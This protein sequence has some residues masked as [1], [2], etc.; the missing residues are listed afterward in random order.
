MLSKLRSMGGSLQALIADLYRSIKGRTDVATHPVTPDIPPQTVGE[1]EGGIKK[2]ETSPVKNRRPRVEQAILR[3][4]QKIASAKKKV[5]AK[6][7]TKASKP[8]EGDR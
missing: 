2:S 6:G 4:S 3:N 5:I 1:S 8:A 7:M